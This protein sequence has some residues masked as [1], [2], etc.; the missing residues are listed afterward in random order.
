MCVVKQLG[1]RRRV[2]TVVVTAVSVVDANAN[3]RTASTSTS[4]VSPRRRAMAF[5][6]PPSISLVIHRR[7]RRSGVRHSATLSFECDMSTPSFRSAAALAPEK[8]VFPLDH[9]AE[10]KPLAAAYVECLREHANDAKACQG[11]SKAYLECRMKRDLMATQPLQELGFRDDDGDDDE[12]K[13]K[14]S[15]SSSRGDDKTSESD[16]KED[17]P[18][19][20]IAGLRAARRK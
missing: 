15:S 5:K 9:F 10:C 14:S 7:Q 17:E 8:G 18:R 13:R 6:P 4:A 3:A 16:A 1:R 2:L 20:H 19:E 11:V 12:R